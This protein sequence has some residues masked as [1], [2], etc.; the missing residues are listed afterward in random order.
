MELSTLES[1]YSGDVA[2]TDWVGI[3]RHHVGG[4]S[5]DVSST[6][7]VQHVSAP[8]SPA[9]KLHYSDAGPHREM[10]VDCPANFVGVKKGPP[11]LPRP[12]SNVMQTGSASPM[13]K[14]SQT[15]LSSPGK[16][17]LAA[18]SSLGVGIV[19]PLSTSSSDL[20]F[21]RDERDRSER[22]RRYQEE[23]AKRREMEE[24][25]NQEQEQLRASLRGSKKMQGLEE[26]RTRTNMLA[27][28]DGFDNPMYRADDGDGRTWQHK[29]QSQLNFVQQGVKKDHHIEHISKSCL[30]LYGAIAYDPLIGLVCKNHPQSMYSRNFLRFLPKFFLTLES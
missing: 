10:A 11:R 28:Q 21:T 8:V 9:S 16:S 3:H 23:L 24:R 18:D 12:L 19:D 14:G 27:V 6:S 15:S 5:D 22:L 2:H 25:M 4:Q 29:K 13:L 30:F 26:K 20:P 7:P 1:G 17:Y